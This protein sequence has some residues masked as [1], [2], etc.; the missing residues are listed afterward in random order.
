MRYEYET[1][2]ICK[3]DKYER[4]IVNTSNLCQKH[5]GNKYKIKKD[6]LG[7]KKLAY[8]LKDKYTEGYYTVFRWI[9]T[10]EDVADIERHLRIDDDVLKFM[11]VKV[12][13][14][15]DEF[16]LDELTEDDVTTTEQD[17]PDALDVL[18]GL[19]HY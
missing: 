9:G 15:E 10:P 4:S 18:L 11:T 2:I 19:A 7:V 8:K 5:T 16:T 3:P 13:A 14:D 6:I 12:E 17:K 1:I